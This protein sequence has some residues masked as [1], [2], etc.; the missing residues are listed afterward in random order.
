MLPYFLD[1]VLLILVTMVIHAFATT[2][3]VRWAADLESRGHL[4]RPAVRMLLVPTMVVGLVLTSLAESSLWAYL[5]YLEGSIESYTDSLYFSIVTFTTLG[6]GDITLLG[7][8][9]IISGLEAATGIVAFGWTSAVLYGLINFIY[10]QEIRDERR[11]RLAAA[12]PDSGTPS[13]R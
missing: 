12:N 1:G 7:D 3:L 9:R 4:E 10:F 5:Y 6:Y 2:A 8:G 11:Q 13:P